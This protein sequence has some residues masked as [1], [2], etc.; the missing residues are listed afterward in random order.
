LN[1]PVEDLHKRCHLPSPNG[2]AGQVAE[3]GYTRR[4]IFAGRLFISF[5]NFGFTA[6]EG[7]V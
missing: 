2:S 4:V 5:T 1:L 3:L 7:D 6:D